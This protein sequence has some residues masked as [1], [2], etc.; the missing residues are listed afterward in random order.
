ME[1]IKEKDKT[2]ILLLKAGGIFLFLIIL[3]ILV[4]LISGSWLSLREF[5]LK[6]LTGSTW[7]PVSDQFGILPFVIGTFITSILSL[8]ISLPFSLSIAILLGFYLRKGWLSRIINYTTDL[9]AGIPSVIY[10]FW[11]LM[12]F[13]PIMRSIEMKLGIV[14]YGIGIFTA[15]IIL[16][17]MIIPYAATTAREAIKMVPKDII[18]A[19]YGLGAYSYAV[20]TKVVIPY[21]KS[22]ILAGILLS[23]GRAFG[24]TMAVTMVIGNSNAIPRSLFEPGN[25]MA[26]VIA[27]EFTEAS[28]DIHLSSLIQIGLWLFIFTAIISYIANIIIKK[29]SVER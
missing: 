4:S 7:D 22:G 24:E 9:I 19:G 10:G 2:F 18:E 27:N 5:G 21:A 1:E 25:T 11:G 8:L 14:P 23:F 13:V 26:S 15:S 16:A 20:V 28:K 12:V 29:T 3:F 6:F 17:I